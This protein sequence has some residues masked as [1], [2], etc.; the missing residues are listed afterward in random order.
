M[1]NDI[2]KKLLE[3]MLDYSASVIKFLDNKSLPKS[4]VDQLVRSVTSIGANYSEAQ[5]A[6]SKKDFVNKIYIAKKEASETSYWLKLV[7]R[8]IAESGEL[9]VFQDKAQHFTM[10]LQKIL[11][12][13]R[14]KS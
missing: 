13:S 11:N 3:E 12:S 7:Q 8:L 1:S 2:S 10:I 9:S 6:S 5:D 14:A 4:V